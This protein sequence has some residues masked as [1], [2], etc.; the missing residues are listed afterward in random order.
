MTYQGITRFL[1]ID[2]P[3]PPEIGVFDIEYLTVANAFIT[4][5][6]K[7]NGVGSLY[8]SLDSMATWTKDSDNL[9]GK[10]GN[11]SDMAICLPLVGTSASQR[12]LRYSSGDGTWNIVGAGNLQELGQYS[13][14]AMFHGEAY[15]A[16]GKILSSGAIGSTPIDPT[17]NFTFHRNCLVDIISG[18]PEVIDS[19]AEIVTPDT[20]NSYGIPLINASSPA[21]PTSTFPVGSVPVIYTN[22]PSEAPDHRAFQWKRRLFSEHN[23]GG[24]MLANDISGSGRQAYVINTS[25]GN[26]VTVASGVVD[27]VPILIANDPD[28][29]GAWMILGDTATSGGAAFTVDGGLS[30][31]NH[32]NAPWATDTWPTVPPPS[33]APTI[34]VDVQF[35]DLSTDDGFGNIVSKRGYV[36]VC[37]NH[38]GPLQVP[39]VYSYWTIDNGATW[40][41]TY[42]SEFYPFNKYFLKVAV[43]PNPDL[44]VRKQNAIMVGYSSSFRG[45]SGVLESA[46]SLGCVGDINLPPGNLPPLFDVAFLPAQGILPDTYLALGRN[47][48]MIRSIN[49]GCDWSDE[50]D[51]VSFAHTQIVAI[52]NYGNTKFIA[53]DINGNIYGSYNGRTPWTLMYSE[54]LGI[55]DTTVRNA[56]SIY[57]HPITSMYSF[58]TWYGNLPPNFVKLRYILQTMSGSS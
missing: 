4:T 10:L 24:R 47:N 55:L 40:T 1:L 38:F 16:Y 22:Y 48:Y 8:R 20:F 43:G 46:W 3:A 2:P 11:F 35:I 31:T 9:G 21:V 30:W 53:I 52:K 6:I 54:P 27:G 13:D 33:L 51:A 42:S 18:L 50:T 25:T 28:N 12:T 32:N 5:V 15:G 17:T 41:R 19:G 37:V 56:G 26:Y 23:S 58:G 45:G 29:A 49:L 7:E 14:Y 36:V 39:Y 57:N 34:P 44:T